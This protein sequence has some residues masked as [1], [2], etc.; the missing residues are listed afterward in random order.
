MH[1]RTFRGVVL[2][3]RWD[4]VQAS[5]WFVPL[6]TA[7]FAFI[8]GQF[9]LWIDSRTTDAPTFFSHL[10]FTGSADDAR[11]ILFPVKVAKDGEAIVRYRV[12]YTW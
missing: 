3:R 2:R 11:T 5:Y 8:L 6:L 1:I 12:R 4:Q 9:M 10:I 7:V